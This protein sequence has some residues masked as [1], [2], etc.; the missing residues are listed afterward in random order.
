[1]ET[2]IFLLANLGFI[3]NVPKSIMTPTQEIEYLVLLVNS[4]TL[5]L[6]L[7]GE[8]LHHIRL[9]V[10]QILQKSHVKAQQLAQIIGKLNAA[11]QA[12]L[13]APLFFWFLQGDLQRA[14]KDNNENYKALLSLSL[15]AQEELSWWQE[16]LAHWNGEALLCHQETMVIES[17][18]SPQ[19]WGAVCNGT[20]T[21]GPWSQLEKQ[22]HI[23]CL[24]LLAATL[25]LKSFVKD[26]TGIAVLLQ[27]DKQTAVAYINNMG[28]TVSPQ[29]TD[30]T[31]ALWM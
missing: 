9:K 11:S 22:M 5:H 19:V 2:L 25:A 20:R 1:M 15:P 27:L 29:L 31:K 14:L 3:I 23:N 21:G 6:S 26:Q 12:V 28:G 30:M 24:E 17:D 16:K 4:T 13:P 7:L 8:K 10:N 18:A